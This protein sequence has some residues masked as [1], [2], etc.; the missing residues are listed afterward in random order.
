MSMPKGG[1]AIEEDPNENMRE[2][3]ALNF[4]DEVRFFS[5]E[6]EFKENAN[7]INKED[8]ML[9]ERKEKNAEIS[10]VLDLLWDK[11][12]P[13]LLKAQIYMRRLFTDQ[14]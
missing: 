9:L 12:V 14:V 3:V 1:G 13:F 6:L 4:D 10:K 7:D 2:S 8:M 11:R 5:K